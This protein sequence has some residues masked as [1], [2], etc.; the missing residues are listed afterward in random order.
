MEIFLEP[1][2][3]ISFLT[4]TILE[5]V[6]GIDNLILI[7]ILTDKLPKEQQVLA[8]RVGIL[9]AVVTRIM[10]LALAF[11]IT[12]MT[13]SLFTLFDIHFSWKEILL[14]IGG[15]F[16][17][18]KAT[19]EIH[20]KIEGAGEAAHG[21]KHFSSFSLVVGQIIVM[22]VVFSFDSVMTAVGVAHHLE[23][24]IAAILVAVVFMLATMET[25]HTFIAKHPTIKVLALSY[26]MLIGLALIGEGFHQP[27]PKGYLYFAM[28]F[29]FGVEVVNMII[30]SRAARI[31][32]QH[33]TAN[34]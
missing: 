10:L 12:Q 24:M 17:L 27:I 28:A 26:M 4:L 25:I 1:A 30:R 13:T 31:A 22:D 33:R 3:I 6:L 32:A 2:V 18:A 9:G 8:R 16:L 7:S 34:S 14:I 20:H 23:V 19:M 11:F 21:P 15:L 5:I 29:S